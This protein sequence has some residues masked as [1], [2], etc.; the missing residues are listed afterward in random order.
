MP[1]KLRCYPINKALEGFLGIKGYW[2]NNKRDMR[3][4]CENS[5]YFRNMVIQSFLNF[6]DIC[7]LFTDTGYISKYLMG[8]RKL[9]ASSVQRF[10]C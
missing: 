7:S 2:P 9:R 3:Y 4:F 8:Y 6:G 5:K 10:L 1:T